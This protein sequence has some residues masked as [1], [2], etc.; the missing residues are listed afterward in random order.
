MNSLRETSQRAS[1]TEKLLNPHRPSNNSTIA[2]NL[3]KNDV[4][5]VIF[6]CKNNTMM[7]CLS[8][9]LFGLPSLHFSY[10]RKIE[11]GLPLFLFNY[12]DRKMYGIYE[13]AGCGQMNIDPYAWTD[14]GAEKTAFPAQVRICIKMQCEPLVEKQ[15]KKAIKDNYYNQVHF[16]FELDHIQTQD[17]IAL[18]RPS[19]FSASNSPR[20][21]NLYDGLLTTER[22][23][24]EPGKWNHGESSKSGER[25]FDPNAEICQSIFIPHVDTHSEILLQQS[26]SGEPTQNNKEILDQLDSL[27]VKKADSDEKKMILSKLSRLAIGHNFSNQPSVCHPDDNKGVRQDIE[28]P[29]GGSHDLTD[30]NTITSGFSLENSKLAE[31]VEVLV[32]RTTALEKKQGEQERIIQQLRDRVSELESKLNPS[33]SFVD[34]VLDQSTGLNLGPG[35]IYL[36]GGYDGRLWLSTMDSFSPS[37]DTLTSLRKMNYARAYAS[38]AALN[39]SIYFFGGGDGS[40]WSDAVERYDPWRN[41]WTLCPP[42]MCEKGSLAGVSLNGKIFAIGGGNGCECFSE[43]E[44]FDPALGRW[45]NSQPMF[46]KRFA[47][48]AAAFQGAMYVIGGFNGKD[49]LR[50]FERCDPREAYW[51]RLPSMNVTRGCHS[52]AVFNDTLYVMGGYDGECM[53]SSVEVFDPRMECWTMAEPMNFSRGYGATVVLGDHLL[54]IGGVEDQETIVESVEYYSEGSGWAVSRLK[55][56]GKRCFFSAIVL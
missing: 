40:S 11:P 15:F 54:T 50:S 46:E 4:G 9:Q 14:G 18:F 6:G 39:G 13:A 30:E 5:G 12:S 51:K 17:L 37:M 34:D 48:T 53:V 49:Y 32:E 56:V 52:M 20:M 27:P 26:L 35:T 7:E 16:W 22:K 8:K 31:M 2:R 1:W 44:M 25:W 29:T 33:T 55:A 47:P 24:I 43:V 42:L 28:P 10:V 36:I 41:E 45:I 23:V 3:A 38:A 21:T 19:G